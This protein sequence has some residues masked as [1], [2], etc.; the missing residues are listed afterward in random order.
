MYS[1]PGVRWSLKYVFVQRLLAIDGYNV[2]RRFMLSSE[3]FEGTHSYTPPSNLHY[4]SIQHAV[5]HAK[6]SIDVLGAEAA[7]VMSHVVFKRTCPFRSDRHY[8]LVL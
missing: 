3:L 2:G 1:I 5:L 7:T 8:Y 6:T 4:L